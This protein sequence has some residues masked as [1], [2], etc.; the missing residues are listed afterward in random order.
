MDYIRFCCHLERESLNICRSKNCAELKVQGKVRI[1]YQYMFSINIT[2]F[3]I[4]KQVE[5][6]TM[7]MRPENQL[8][9]F[10]QNL[11]LNNLQKQFMPV[12]SCAF[13][14]V[15]LC[16]LYYNRKLAFVSLKSSVNEERTYENC[17]AVRIFPNVLF[18]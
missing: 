13:R 1:V 3:E 12:H 16:C 9:D 10:D 11:Y 8:T 7:I 15:C 4:I 17:C 5:L 6:L 2:L 18:F 14:S